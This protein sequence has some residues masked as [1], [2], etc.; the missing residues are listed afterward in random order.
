MT[1][2]MS[3]YRLHEHSIK[4]TSEYSLPV[5][6]YV[7]KRLRLCLEEYVNNVM[8]VAIHV[9]VLHVAGVYCIY[10]CRITQ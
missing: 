1:A 8:V 5:F 4:P 9:S 2:E 7:L 10:I 3:A 6:L